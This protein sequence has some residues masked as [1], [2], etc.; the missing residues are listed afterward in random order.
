[1]TLPFTALT[2]TSA[3][4]FWPQSAFPSGGAAVIA[5]SGD[6]GHLNPAISTAGPIHAVAG[7]MF[8]GLVELDESSSPSPDLAEAWEAS[9]DG[10]SMTFHLRRGLLWHDGQPF[11][12]EDVKVTSQDLLFRFHARARAGLAISVSTVDIVDPHT[13]TFRLKRPH[14][15]LLRQL[16]VTEAPI[17]PA[18]LFAGR[19][20]TNTPANL[21]PIGTGPVRFESWRRDDQ[22]VLVRNKIY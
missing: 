17:L 4:A 13:V 19:D 8:N 22:V 2:V 5:V 21:C 9:G 20:R 10:L 6:P 16:S 7:S 1:M 11:T 14:P 12:A 15:A 18:H 3:V